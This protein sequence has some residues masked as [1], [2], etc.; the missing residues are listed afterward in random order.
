MALTTVGDQPPVGLTGSGLLELVCELRRADVIDPKGRIV[1]EHAIFGQRLSYDVEGVRRFLITDQG[2]DRRGVDA[3]EAG[4]RVSLYLTQHD[5]RELQKAKGAIRATFDTLMAQ[6]DLQP[7]DLQRMIL[8]GSFGSQLDV[9]AV[10][11]LGMIPPVPFEVIETS[12]NGAGFGA[13]LML[14]D[15]EFARG[16][17]IAAVGRT[18]GPGCR[19]QL[20]PAFYPVAGAHARGRQMT[21]T[22]SAETGLTDT[23]ARPAVPAQ[24]A[25]G[26]TGQR[27][28]LG[29][30]LVVLATLFWSTAG[31]FITTTVRGSGISALGLAFWRVFVAFLCLAV[32]IGVFRP[33]ALRVHRPRS[34]L[35]GRDGPG[36]GH[37]SGALDS[38]DLNQR[39]IRIHR[40]P[41]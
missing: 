36:G 25:I 31:V 19:P 15:A 13:A 27:R 40:D 9:E 32:A 16:E 1:S 17:R 24:Q 28:W 6:L 14:D 35:V 10:L 7:A 11:S 5:V 18:G 4:T 38:G 20:R 2:V 29:F 12:P 8:T 23:G 21:E 34:A 33:R 3:D 30:G 41:V 22:P 26:T 39:C 37:V